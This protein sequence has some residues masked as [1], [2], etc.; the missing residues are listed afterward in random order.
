MTAS[1]QLELFPRSGRMIAH[2][3]R[4]NLREIIVNRYRII[5]Y[6]RNEEEL[7]IIGVFHS[8]KQN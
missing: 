8:S 4:D 5:Y 3:R 6:L 2:F 1:E 7:E